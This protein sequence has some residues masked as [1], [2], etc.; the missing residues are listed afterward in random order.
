MR[1][2]LLPP[3]RRPR[4][5]RRGRA[6]GLRR[7]RLVEEA[8][9]QQLERPQGPAQEG[10]R[11]PRQERRA[12]PDAPWPTSRARARRNGTFALKLHGPFQSRGAKKAPLL[13]WKV[14]VAG[15]GQSQQA[16]LTVTDDNAYVGFRGPAVRGGHATCSS[17]TCARPQRRVDQERQDHVHRAGRRPGRLDQGPQGLRRPGRGRG[18]HPAGQRHRGRAHDGGRL[19]QGPALA[20]GKEQLRRQG[21]SP[22]RIPSSPR[23]SW[24]RSTRRSS[25]PPSRW[26]WTTRTAPG[27]W[28]YAVFAAPSGSSGSVK[29]GTVRFSYALP[30]VGTKPEDHRARR[31]PSRWRCCSSSWAPGS[32]LPGG[33]PEDPVAAAGLGCWS[34]PGPAPGEL[35]Q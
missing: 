15:A 12:G 33:G 34:R 26:T 27:R 18:L 21:Q 19:R 6:R 16:S 35:M 10:L 29:G 7:R 24:T 3:A 9:L 22:S 1:T 4:R 25:G 23:A 20:R 11:H 30:E 32:A 14:E 31:T 28:R 8:R 17:A 5:A 13:D 2:R